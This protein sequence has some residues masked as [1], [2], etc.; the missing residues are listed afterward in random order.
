MP[1]HF[2]FATRFCN[3]DIGNSKAS[4][5]FDH[6]LTPDQGIEVLTAYFKTSVWV[7]GDDWFVSYEY[8][9]AGRINCVAAGQLMSPCQPTTPSYVNGITYYPHGAIAS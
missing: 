3:R 7:L 6:R 5:E 8:D 4:G 2:V 1:L 9:T